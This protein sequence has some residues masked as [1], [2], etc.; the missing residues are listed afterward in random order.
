MDE[1]DLFIEHHGPEL[2]N[3]RRNAAMIAGCGR[4]IAGQRLIILPAAPE[5]LVKL[6]ELLTNALLASCETA[7]VTSAPSCK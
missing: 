1:G 7:R 5:A 2:L 4:R 6:R 3:T